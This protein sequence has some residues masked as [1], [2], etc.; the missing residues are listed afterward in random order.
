ME[1]NINC[2]PIIPMRGLVVFPYMTL[3]FDAGRDISIRA[4]DAAIE[5][6]TSVFLVT[7]KN[8]DA[9]A[10]SVNDLYDVGTIARVKQTMRMPNGVTR[11]IVE[12]LRRGYVR[13]VLS[14]RPYMNGVIEEM[15]EPYILESPLKDAY[16]LRMKKTYEE[17]FTVSPKVSMDDFMHIVTMDSPERIC[18]SIAGNVDF[19]IETKQKILG[20]P[21]I[22]D[23]IE[24]LILA[25]ANHTQIVELEGRIAQKVKERMDEHQ[26]E[27]YMREQLRVIQEELGDGITEEA[28]EYEERIRK[29]KAKKEVK[30]FKGS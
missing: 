15:E 5:K 23:R 10:P 24:E 21:D 30:A 26:K 12:G 6:R 11:V 4:I 8:S 17:Y 9:E 25:L 22:R 2:M 20:S 7:Q 1:N 19:N 18:D 29:L 13:E 3:N 16:V 14:L 27:Y 28:A